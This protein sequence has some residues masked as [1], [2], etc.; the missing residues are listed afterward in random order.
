MADRL[1]HLFQEWA[2]LGGRVLLAKLDPD[3]A[4]RRP[5][6]V[7]AESTGYC[8]DSGRLTWIVLDWLT[9]NAAHVDP[10]E[11]IARTR[12][13]GDR[14]VLGV[15]A[16]AA[17]VRIPHPNLD[18]IKDACE[19]HE[20]LEPFFHRVARSP[21]ASRLAEENAVDV[22]RRWNYYSSELQYLTSQGGSTR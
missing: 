8:R 15:V 21:L 7:I 3:V 14:A 4:P 17:S 9:R 12:E 22:F 2:K 19:A 6:E 11:L 13:V 20:R 1:D 10:V 18:A 16:D 5:E